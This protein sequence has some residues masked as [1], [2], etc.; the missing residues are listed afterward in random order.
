MNIFKFELKT[1]YK[2][3]FIWSISIVLMLYSNMM[4]YPSFADNAS[5]LDELTESVDSNILAA[6]GLDGN[7]QFSSVTG[8]FA[9]MYMYIQLFI[10]IQAS[11]YGFNVLSIEER[12]LTADFL[13]SKP[14]K[15]ST[16]YISKFLA[17]FTSLTITNIVVWIASILSVLMFN[18]GSEFDM[19]MIIVLLSSNVLFQ[20]FFLTLGMAI[21]MTLKKINT[22]L[23]LSISLSFGMYLIHIIKE[24]IG[25]T[26]FSLITPFSYFEPDN[27]LYYGKYDLIDT[28]ICIAVIVVSLIISYILYLKRNIRSL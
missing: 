17:A 11:N 4:F 14:V 15:R 18:G 3:I 20:L 8:Y 22:V 7:L 21:S 9:M 6:F 10:A 2:S 24:I 26:F 5:I 27:I 13:L 19:G 16:I 1:Y 28:T 12:E 25:G 23:T